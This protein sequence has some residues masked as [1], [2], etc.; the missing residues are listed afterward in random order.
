[1]S[2]LKMLSLFLVLG[3]AFVMT[4]CGGSD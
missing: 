1:M 3:V 4:G 2:T